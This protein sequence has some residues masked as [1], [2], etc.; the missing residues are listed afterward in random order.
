MRKRSASKTAPGLLLL[1]LATLVLAQPAA[2]LNA[3][4]WRGG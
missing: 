4:C 2:A 3:N 1:S